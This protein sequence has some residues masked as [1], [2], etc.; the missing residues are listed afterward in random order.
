MEVEAAPGVDD[1]K[2]GAEEA[3]LA[4][5]EVDADVGRK[6]KE[7]AAVAVAGVG[8]VVEPGVG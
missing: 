5:C 4:G 7:E 2:S 1:G 8:A 3:G 6:L